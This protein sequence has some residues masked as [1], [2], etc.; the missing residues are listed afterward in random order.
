MLKGLL[1]QP[2]LLAWLL[3][4]RASYRAAAGLAAMPAV[5]PAP[6]AKPAAKPAP[7]AE[8]R[9]ER[10]WGC[11]LRWPTVFFAPNVGIG[12]ALMCA[13]V[14][15]PERVDNCMRLLPAHACC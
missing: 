5:L 9:C 14:V 15:L 7:G 10:V 4:V 2:Q 1:K 12:R 8:V 3:E 6:A 11:C 13:A